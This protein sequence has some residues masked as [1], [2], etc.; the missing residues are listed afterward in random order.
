MP[1]PSFTVR[2]ILP[3]HREETIE[4]VNQFFRMLNQLPLDGIFRV[5]PRAATKMVDIYLKLRGT[6][7]IVFI[8]GFLEEELVS[9]LIARVEEKPYLEEEKNLFIDLAVTKQGKRKSGFMRPLVEETFRWAKENG[10]QAVEL[11]AVTRNEGAVE[12]WK[13]MG[14]DPF[15]IRF[16]KSVGDR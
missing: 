16:R 2:P 1:N 13:K 7:K 6:E 15:Y 14:F 5:R 8:G 10:I 3:E 9:I 11:R 12:F 4:I